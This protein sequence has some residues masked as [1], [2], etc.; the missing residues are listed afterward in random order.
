M[1]DR[2]L[3]IPAVRRR[4]LNDCCND[5]SYGRLLRLPRLDLRPGQDRD[6]RGLPAHALEVLAYLLARAALDMWAQ[7]RR[8]GEKLALLAV[9]DAGVELTLA[10]LAGDAHEHQS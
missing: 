4:A 9:G 8:D 3:R 1:N 2:Y 10:E 5:G 6:E 7:D